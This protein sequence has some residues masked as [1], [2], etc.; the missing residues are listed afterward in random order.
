MML[1]KPVTGKKGNF[2]GFS[3]FYQYYTQEHHYSFVI[4][5]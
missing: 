2:K 3:L 4:K 1:N 5:S